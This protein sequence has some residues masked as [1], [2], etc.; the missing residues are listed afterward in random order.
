MTREEAFAMLDRMAKGIA[1]MFGTNCETVIN[2]LADPLH[3]VLAIYNGHVSGRS[4]G[5][6]RDV[7]GVEQDLYLDTD[8]V[9]LLA[10]TPSGQQTKSSTFSIKGEDYHYGFGINY[11]FTPLAYA[12]RVLL[13]LMHTEVDF[14]SALYKPRDTGIGEL[15]DA[16]VLRIGKP[17]RDMNKA[18]RIR[19]IEHLKE[20]DAFSYRRAVPYVA[21]HLGVSRYT[22]YKYL[23]EVNA[24]PES[25]Q[26]DLDSKEDL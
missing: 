11:D 22:I 4:V 21:T 24:K 8:V 5:S 23:D 12:N 1:E 14:H 6:T 7:T 3:P 2:D 15:F 20:M 13:D 25:S 17:I 16:A 9:N 10:V 19:V 26:A 18:D